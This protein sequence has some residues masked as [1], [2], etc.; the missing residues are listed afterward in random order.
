M[1][2]LLP[3]WN[4]QPVVIWLDKAGMP[5]EGLLLGV[6]LGALAVACALSASVRLVRS[7][8]DRLCPGQAWSRFFALIW[9]RARAALCSR[10]SFRALTGFLFLFLLTT[11]MV[12]AAVS[13][14][15]GGSP[16]DSWPLAL[17]RVLVM[18]TLSSIVI[19]LLALLN[20][21]ALEP[22]S[23]LSDWSLEP[24]FQRAC[25]QAE[26]FLDARD[27]AR[28]IARST[29]IRIDEPSDSSGRRGRL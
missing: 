19:G 11:T 1:N 6:A 14:I 3:R 23:A 28:T 9:P 7:S 20:D 15:L 25:L 16:L 24:Q 17:L 18:I 26:P 12:A 2:D 5:W 29:P 4:A 22:A 27:E 21:I 10:G 8:R 13:S